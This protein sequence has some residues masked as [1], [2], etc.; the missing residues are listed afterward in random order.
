MKTLITFCLLCAT[1]HA[2]LLT[3]DNP[4]WDYKFAEFRW[5]DTL[6]D[7]RLPADRQ[8]GTAGFRYDRPANTV[9]ADGIQ[10]G[11]DGRTLSIGGPQLVANFTGDTIGPADEFFDHG[12][13]FD[14]GLLFLG[15]A[16]EE[17]DGL[18]YG[19]IAIAS[20]FVWEGVE[21]LHEWRAAFWMH[22]TSP[23]TPVLI[24]LPRPDFPPTI[25]EPAAGL[26]LSAAAAGVLIAPRK[27][28]RNTY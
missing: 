10:G 6:L 21:L 24:A 28:L 23:N 14:G 2:E 1:A 18:H 9:T 3:F 7:P 17:S 19:A 27:I 13:L 15:Y 5:S 22:E 16:I 12:V 20:A 11:V 25:P 8:T 4:G 26:L